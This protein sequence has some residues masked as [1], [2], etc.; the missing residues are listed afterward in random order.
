MDR[1]RICRISY[2]YRK[3]EYATEQRLIETIWRYD[4]KSAGVKERFLFNAIDIGT[5]SRI[6]DTQGQDDAI[7]MPLAVGKKYK[8]TRPFRGTGTYLKYDVEVVSLEKIKVEAGEFEAYRIN[9]DGWWTREDLI[10]SVS[11]QSHEVMYYAPAAKRVVK[12]EFNNRASNGKL[13][14][15]FTEELIKWEPKAALATALVRAT[16]SEQGTSAPK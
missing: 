13:W 11:G 10:P 4:Y 12:F 7:Q 14:D 8:I 2:L 5:G 16:T 9:L 3:A 6:W 1:L 15:S